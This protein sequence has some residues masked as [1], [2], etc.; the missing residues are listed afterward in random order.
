MAEEF[1]YGPQ[2]GPAV[3]QMGGKSVSQRMWADILNHSGFDQ[4]CFEIA[5][6]TTRGQA[7]TTGIEEQGSSS[8]GIPRNSR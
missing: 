7:T 5:L 2:I 1:L 3:Q 8:P 4:A 6:D